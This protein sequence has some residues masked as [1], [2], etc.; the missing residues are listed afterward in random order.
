MMIGESVLN[1]MVAGAAMALVAVD[2]SPVSEVFN[3][4]TGLVATF[5]AMGGACRALFL[6]ETWREAMRVLILGGMLAFG[7]G[8]LG[9]LFVIMYFKD[10]PDSI[11]AHPLTAYNIAF[12]VGLTSVTL[13][14]WLFDKGRLLRGDDRDAER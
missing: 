11:W 5:G 13:L 12:F 2:V 10:A 3:Q 4:H 14:G 9:T 1:S 8:S 6:R 7:I